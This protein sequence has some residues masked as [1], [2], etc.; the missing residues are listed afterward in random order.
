VKAKQDAAMARG[1]MRPPDQSLVA[2][3]RLAPRT[4]VVA[5]VLRVVDVTNRAAT[6]P[7]AVRALVLGQACHTT[8]MRKR[9]NILRTTFNH[10]PTRTWA[11]KAASTPLATNQVAA[12]AASPTP[13]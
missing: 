12:L 5:K 4:Q 1:R 7:N 3:A 2:I 9:P 8:M 6:A 11:R 13:P 10:A